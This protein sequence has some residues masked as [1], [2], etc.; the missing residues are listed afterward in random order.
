MRRSPLP[1]IARGSSAAFIATFTALVSHVAAGG[2]MPAATGL[3]V[4]LLLSAAVCILLAGR[5]LSA[6]RLSVAVLISQG[7]FHVLFVLGADP[8]IVGHLHGAELT[9]AM[10]AAAASTTTTIVPTTAAMWMGHAVAAALTITALHRG[11]SAV[12]SG[13]ALVREIVAASARRVRLLLGAIATRRPVR[14]P[15]PAPRRIVPRPA[16]LLRS[17]RRRGPPLAPFAVS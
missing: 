13:L 6:V 12:R 1:R 10:S 14:T 8:L 16:P 7:I 3:I 11:E 4:P 9:A 17:V 5:R 15:I 2:A